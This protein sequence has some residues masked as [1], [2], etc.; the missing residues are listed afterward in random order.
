MNLDLGPGGHR[1]V[2]RAVDSSADTQP[3]SASEVWSF[4]GYAN[5]PRHGLRVTAR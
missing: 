3:K 2:A 1:I 5:N 4:E